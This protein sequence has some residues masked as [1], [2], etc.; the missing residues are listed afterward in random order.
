MRFTSFVC[1]TIS[2]KLCIEHTWSDFSFILP[3]LIPT[4]GSNFGMAKYNV[5]NISVNPSPPTMLTD[6][7][8]CR[9]GEEKERRM[10]K[11]Y[12]LMILTFMWCCK[13]RNLSSSG[14]DFCEKLHNNQLKALCVSHCNNNETI[15]KTMNSHSQQSPSYK[16]DPSIRW[17]YEWMNNVCKLN[18]WYH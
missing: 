2:D 4:L 17:L 8:W 11:I 18:M 14:R 13:R 15:H 9:R 7:V 1:S 12:G 5:G 3:H 6:C 10:K 16:V